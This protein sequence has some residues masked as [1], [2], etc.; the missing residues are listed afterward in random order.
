MIGKRL[1]KV[2]REFLLIFFILNKKKFPAYNSEINSN[3][4]KKIIVLM[5][6]NKEKEGWHYLAV[7]MYL[8]YC[9]E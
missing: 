3:F 9:M 2:Y 6:A 5:I 8:H 1:R 7:N 4:E